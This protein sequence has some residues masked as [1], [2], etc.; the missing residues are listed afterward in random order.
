MTVDCAVNG[1]DATD[2]GI[3]KAGP[4]KLTLG[5]NVTLNR[6]MIRWFE[7]SLDSRIQANLL[8]VGSGGG[9]GPNST[10]ISNRG[11]LSLL[12]GVAYTT[13]LYTALCASRINLDGA[14]FTY[15]TAAQNYDSPAL[16][17]SDGTNNGVLNLTNSGKFWWPNNWTPIATDVRGS[18]TVVMNSKVDGSG[19]PYTLTTPGG[20][21]KPSLLTVQGTLTW[22]SNGTAPGWISTSM[23]RGPHRAWITGS[24]W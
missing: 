2:G 9:Y 14:V 5:R 23:A 10:V 3:C 7:G 22:A 13:T 15:Q 18:G 8:M 1:L 12:P 4:G 19:T 16:Y 24:W 17:L 20:I 6:P 11:T 21:W